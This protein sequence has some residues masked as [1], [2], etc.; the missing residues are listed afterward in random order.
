MAICLYGLVL[1]YGTNA[2]YNVYISLTWTW[3][4]LCITP[5]LYCIFFTVSHGSPATIP[6]VSWYVPPS[7]EVSDHVQHHKLNRKQWDVCNSRHLE[8]NEAFVAMYG[9]SYTLYT[10]TYINIVCRSRTNNSVNLSVFCL[11]VC[12][13]R[14]QDEDF[15]S[16]R[17]LLSTRYDKLIQIISGKVIMT[18]MIAPFT[19]PEKSNQILTH[20]TL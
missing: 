15:V 17:G 16:F 13:L 7:A 12:I 2:Q 8:N 11:Y 3:L 6:F 20:E 18:V 14:Y 5:T 19:K 1:L 9:Y 10:R 4:I